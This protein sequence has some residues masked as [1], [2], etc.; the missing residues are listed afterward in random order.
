M[1]LSSIL[2]KSILLIS[3]SVWLVACGGGGKSDSDNSDSD[4]NSNI[5][6]WRTPVILETVVGSALR[7]QIAIGPS[8]NAIAVWEQK[9]GIRRGIYANYFSAALDGA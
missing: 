7:P 1:E 9:D 4:G 2:W 6:S 3:L 5:K 8:G